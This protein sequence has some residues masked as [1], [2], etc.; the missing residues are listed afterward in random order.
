MVKEHA[1]FE[2][3][4]KSKASKSN[5]NANS[6][7][8]GR[9]RKEIEDAVGMVEENGYL[10]FQGLQGL[11]RVLGLCIYAVPEGEETRNQRTS[12]KGTSRHLGS[13]E[14]QVEREKREKEFTMQFWNLVN[15]HLFNYVETSILI[16]ILLYLFTEDEKNAV[17]VRPSALR[18]T[19]Y[20]ASRSCRT[21]STTRSTSCKTKSSKT[22]FETVNR[23][24]RSRNVG[25]LLI[26][27]R[28]DLE[29]IVSVF[30]SLNDNKLGYRSMK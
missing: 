15:R 11:F 12:P 20:R 25:K 28:W 7:A 9:R 1:D 3:N 21:R 23:T 14:T 13:K 6:L 8:L 16:D 18:L 27:D 26:E 30:K 17:R 24:C 10:S 19:P 4:M 5:A 29:E 22:T 2:R